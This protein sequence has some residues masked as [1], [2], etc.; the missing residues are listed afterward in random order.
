MTEV[1]AVKAKGFTLIELMVVVAIAG[2][3][4]AFGYPAY[5]GVIKES[6]RKTAQSDLMAFAAAMERHHTGSFTYKGAASAGA[7]TGSPEVFTSW[8]PASEA[9]GNKRYNLS[10]ESASG[11]DYVIKATPVSGK[12]QASDGTIWYYS[13]GRKAWDENNSGSIDSS[14]YCWSC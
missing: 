8:S 10:I 9:S 2:I 6:Y 12:S 14:E 1:T 13:D 5:Q 3:L 4:V 11:V 7:D